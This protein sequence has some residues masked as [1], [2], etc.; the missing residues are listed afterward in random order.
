MTKHPV[1]RVYTE[2]LIDIALQKGA[3]E[4]TGAELEQFLRLVEKDARI[5]ALLES[6][7]IETTA[8]LD[9]LHRALHGNV[10]EL[11][12]DFLGLL[13]RKGRFAA[14]PSIVEA[15]RATADEHAGRT[16]VHVATAAPI[17]PAL[18]EEIHAAVARALDREVVLEDDVEPALV[19]GA[20]IT[21][22]DRVYDGSLST[23]LTKYKKQIMRS[24]GY[25]DQG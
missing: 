12:E 17:A 2:A 14:L 21:I 7:V 22:G 25:E 9:L 16:R 23:R 19:G 8:K 20:V 4:A 1:A 18:R 15:Y 24:G 10:S 5:A 11:V 3:V 6:P 13:L